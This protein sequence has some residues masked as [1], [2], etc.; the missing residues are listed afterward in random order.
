MR[1]V[2]LRD[3]FVALSHTTMGLS[4]PR[5]IWYLVHDHKAAMCIQ[6]RWRTWCW[7]AH[8]RVPEWDTIRTHLRE[9]CM[10]RALHAYSA[11]RREWRVDWNCWR[12]PSLS[13]LETILQEARQGLWGNFSPLC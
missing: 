3:K 9:H 4:L 5:E 1:T 11:V 7:Y 13:D 8:T 6:R 2:I 12:S 10:H